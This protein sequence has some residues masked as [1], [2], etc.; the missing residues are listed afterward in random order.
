[1]IYFKFVSYRKLFG[2]IF[3]VDMKLMW[4]ICVDLFIFIF[5]V[6]GGFKEFCIKLLKGDWIVWLN[7]I[8][9]KRMGKNGLKY[10]RYLRERKRERFI[11]FC[12]G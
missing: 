9:N 2:N 3:L 4:I 11:L 10:S 7:I 1:M 12:V 8:Y 6:F 5:L